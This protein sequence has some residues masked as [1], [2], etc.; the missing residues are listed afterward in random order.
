MGERMGERREAIGEEWGG[1][2]SLTSCR[3]SWLRCR[4]STGIEGEHG[5]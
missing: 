3:T 4:C 2:G 1:E 5:G